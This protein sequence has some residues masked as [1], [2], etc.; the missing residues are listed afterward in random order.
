MRQATPK[1]AQEAPPL[2]PAQLYVDSDEEEDLRRPE[3]QAA[4][5]MPRPEVTSVKREHTGIE[6]TLG[7]RPRRTARQPQWLHD[8]EH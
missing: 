8:Y 3:P 5:V 7:S 6:A 2:F 4:E 1:R